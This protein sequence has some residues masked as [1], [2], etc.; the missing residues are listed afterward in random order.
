VTNDDF[1]SHK[2]LEEKAKAEGEKPKGRPKDVTPCVWAA[3]SL[4]LTREAA[5]G[6]LALPRMRGKF[7]FLAKVTIT[8]E[9]GV[10]I[11]K[12]SHISFWRYATFKPTVHSVEAI[13]PEPQAAEEA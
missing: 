6:V 2:V 3:T 9:C 13:P 7:K 8:T 1:A 12:R 5:L 10:S 4:W 11:L